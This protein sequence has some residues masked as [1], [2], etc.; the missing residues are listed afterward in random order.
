MVFIISNDQ[1]TLHQKDFTYGF[2]SLTWTL[3]FQVFIHNA[4][5]NIRHKTFFTYNYYF[6]NILL[7]VDLLNKGH[8]HVP[9]C[10]AFA[11]S[12][13]HVM[14]MFLREGKSGI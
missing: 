5:M 2:S 1:I 13:Y 8:D 4:V 11:F 14:T 9:A 10:S 7:K 12:M 3:D 6:N